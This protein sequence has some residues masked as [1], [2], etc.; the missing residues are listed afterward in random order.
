MP[1]ALFSAITQHVAVITDVSGQPIVSHIWKMGPIVCPETSVKN[2]HCSLRSNPEERSYQ[3]L[4]GGSQK[5]RTD[6]C[7]TSRGVT[8]N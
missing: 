8:T 5:S 4:I 6:L 2:Y 1:T 3:L 7:V